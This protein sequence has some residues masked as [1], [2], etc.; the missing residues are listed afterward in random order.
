MDMSFTKDP[1][2]IAQRQALW[3]DCLESRSWEEELSKKQLQGLHTYFMTGNL[4][5]GAPKAI[6][7]RILFFPKVDT[8]G[9]QHVLNYNIPEGATDNDISALKLFFSVGITDVPALSN[10]EAADIFRYVYGESYRSDWHLPF[11]INDET[12]CRR[13]LLDPNHQF[14]CGVKTAGWLKRGDVSQGMWYHLKDYWLSL[15]DHVDPV[16]FRLNDRSRRPP[17]VNIKLVPRIFRRLLGFCAHGIDISKGSDWGAERR[18]YMRDFR[19]RMDGLDGPQELLELW[20]NVK[21]A[22]P[23]EFYTIE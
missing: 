23:S 20:S 15:L 11:Y 6:E 9:I 4:V 7:E 12:T 8:E 5:P 10:E 13:S 14:S 21:K 22:D 17:N 19:E 1:E 16:L 2:W 18:Q 3:K